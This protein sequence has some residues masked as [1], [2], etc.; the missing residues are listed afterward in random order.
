MNERIKS[1]D[2]RKNRFGDCRIRS[3]MDS[4]KLGRRCP[5]QYDRLLIS[6][7]ELFHHLFLK[8]R[9]S[10]RAKEGCSKAVM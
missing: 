7:V 2:D 5:S 1:R 3:H 4:V 6:V 9:A 10:S 8:K